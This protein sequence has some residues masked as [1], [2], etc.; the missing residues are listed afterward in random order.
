MLTIGQAPHES[1]HLKILLR[2]LHRQNDASLDEIRRE[3]GPAIL[4]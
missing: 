3:F 2:E 4:N 1:Q